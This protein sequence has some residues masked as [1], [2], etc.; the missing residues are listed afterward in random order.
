MIGIHA[1][2][3]TAEL[4]HGAAEATG[5][6]GAATRGIRR[7]GCLARNRAT[8]DAAPASARINEE[9]Q[10][11]TARARASAIMTRAV[12]ISVRLRLPAPENAHHGAAPSAH[13][14]HTAE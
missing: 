2:C 12:F 5:T 9:R 7:T 13:K 3:T 8:T 4:R 14:M 6:A 1:A 11:S 10:Q